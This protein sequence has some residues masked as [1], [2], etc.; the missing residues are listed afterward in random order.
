M[1]AFFIFKSTQLFTK[2]LPSCNNSKSA[3]LEN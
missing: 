3:S 2:A 1:E